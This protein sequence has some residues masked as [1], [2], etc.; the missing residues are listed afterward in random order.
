M[1]AFLYFFPDAPKPVVKAADIP[2]ECNLS[3]ILDGAKL[4]YALGRT[5][6]PEGS[7]GYLVAVRPA[8]ESRAAKCGYY[9]DE[10]RWAKVRGADGKVTHWIGYE[11]ANP[12]GPADLA[13]PRMVEGYPVT[14]ADGRQWVIPSVHVPYTT[15]PKICRADED[16]NLVKSVPDEY[17]EIC[18]L[19]AK[20]FDCIRDVSGFDFNEFVEF[21][22]RLLAINYRIGRREMLE[23]GLLADSAACIHDIIGA[24]VGMNVVMAEL[25]AQ[26]K[27]LDTLQ[28]GSS[29]E[30]G[31]EG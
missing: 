16:G 31:S 10:Q 14:L 23:L 13:R 28:D 11:K 30:L 20:F 6:G 8:D 9:P 26:K 2:A 17:E 18:S 4:A 21:C 27:M 19:G 25:E 22:W 24:A 29:A 1:S 7:S 5:N 3:G 12:P 15:L